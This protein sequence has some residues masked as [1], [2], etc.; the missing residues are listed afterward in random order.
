MGDLEIVGHATRFFYR[1]IK[2]R[3]FRFGQARL[4]IGVQGLPVGLAAKQL[5]FPPGGARVNRLFFRA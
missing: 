4:R 5:A 1:P 3:L 2:K